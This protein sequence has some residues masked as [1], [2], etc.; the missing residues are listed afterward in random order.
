MN[1]PPTQILSK[2]TIEKPSLLFV[3]L[4]SS[5]QPRHQVCHCLRCHR[6]ANTVIAPSTLRLPSLCHRHRHHCTYVVTPT[7]SLLPSLSQQCASDVATPILVA[8]NATITA[9]KLRLPLSCHHHCCVNVVTPMLSLM[10]SLIKQHPS[11]VASPNRCACAN[12]VVAPTLPLP[13]SRH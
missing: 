4:P 8:P 9:P 13:S 2:S 6:R 12:A 11:N 7:S 1:R 5:P 3:V 10:P